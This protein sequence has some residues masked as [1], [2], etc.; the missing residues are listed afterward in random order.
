MR[1]KTR[2]KRTGLSKVL[3]EIRTSITG[4]SSKLSKKN[5]RL[6]WK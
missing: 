2:T 4:E 1:K 5:K 3:G 6:R